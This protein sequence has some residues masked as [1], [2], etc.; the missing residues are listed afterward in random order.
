MFAVLLLPVMQHS[1]ITLVACHRVGA[2]LL[3]GFL[4]PWMFFD[5]VHA[6]SVDG[7][8]VD[9]VGFSSMS[10]MWYLQAVAISA[11]CV[12]YGFQKRCQLCRSVQ[13]IVA[14]LGRWA[15]WKSCLFALPGQLQK[16]YKSCSHVSTTAES[17]WRSLD[18]C[19]TAFWCL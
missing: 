5:C 3:S 8:F 14:H 11:V 18:P 10:V 19:T 15:L 12:G 4:A 16:A 6:F 13:F 9:C 7:H 2:Q 1:A 17:R